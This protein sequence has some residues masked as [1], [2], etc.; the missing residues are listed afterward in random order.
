[1][2]ISFCVF[3][4]AIGQAVAKTP[5]VKIPETAAMPFG[6]V[7]YLEWAHLKPSVT[8]NLSGS[9]VPWL[10]PEDLDFSWQGIG[11]SGPNQYGYRPLLE[12]IA[13]YYGVLPSNVTT[14]SGT[15]MA[16]F[17]ACAALVDRGDEVIVEKPCYGPLLDLPVG[18]GAR[19][20]RLERRFE[21]GYCVDTAQLKRIANRRTK[22]IILTNLHNPSGVQIP[23]ETLEEIGEIARVCKAH[24]LVDEVY[25]DFLVEK[26]FPTCSVLG[27]EFLV[28]NSLTKVYGLDGLRCGWVLCSEKLAERLNRMRDYVDAN[29]PFCAEM[30]AARIFPRLQAIL[31]DKTRQI[32]ENNNPLVNDFV[33]SRRE[34]SWVRPDGGVICFPRHRNARKL[35][36]ATRKLL[37]DY[38]T[39]VVPG[40]FFESARHFRLGFGVDRETLAQG[41][42]N[43][44]TALD[45]AAE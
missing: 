20:K 10:Q 36:T 14:A 16:N 39:L 21:D 19:I 38:D 9:S 24:V 29:G 5:E 22:L 1:M 45:A 28:T 43:L 7:K 2:A 13:A 11:F 23:R 12:A 37:Q 27:K 6:T 18:L 31:R 3:A 25:F 15:S 26:P 4:A 40:R 42:R 34:L 17:L 44:G 8:Y 30:A 41:L 32:V 33:N 35:A